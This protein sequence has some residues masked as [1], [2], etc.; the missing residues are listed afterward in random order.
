MIKTMKP[1]CFLVHI[2]YLKPFWKR[3]IKEGFAPPKPCQNQGG[4]SRN[5]P[6]M[7]IGTIDGNQKFLAED[8][9]LRERFGSLSHDLQG[10]IHSK[11]STVV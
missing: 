3:L 9:Q 11:G 10:F 4:K 1:R 2:D 7:G 6:R 5:R 8:N